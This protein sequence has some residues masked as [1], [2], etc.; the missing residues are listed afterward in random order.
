[1][2]ID[3]NCSNYRWFSIAMFSYQMA[4]PFRIS[5]VTNG[6]FPW[7]SNIVQSELSATMTRG[8][9]FHHRDPKTRFGY[10][11]KPMGSPGVQI[12]QPA[13]F[14][15]NFRVYSAHKIWWNLIGWY[16]FGGATLLQ[17]MKTMFE[18]CYKIK[19]YCLLLSKPLCLINNIVILL[20]DI[21]LKTPCLMG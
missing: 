1:M 21:V 10:E 18:I 2:K 15:W 4:P 20:F 16:W 8:D 5:I 13:Q 9:E 11:S 19:Y 3:Q 7:I 17:N 6:G 14:P 12:V